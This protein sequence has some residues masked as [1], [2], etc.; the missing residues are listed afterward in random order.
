[1]IWFKNY[2]HHQIYSTNG[3]LLINCKN[4]TSVCFSFLEFCTIFNGKH[5]YFPTLFIFSFWK[6]PYNR[7][8]IWK[9]HSQTK[10]GKYWYLFIFP[11]FRKQNL[12]WKYLAE[13]HIK[14]V[15]KSIFKTYPPSS[16]IIN[17]VYQ[18]VF[19]HIL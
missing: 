17:S 19:T 12:V 8:C 6:P 16:K 1:M 14:Q 7:L 18:V 10:Y 5:I 11:S 3:F 15:L 2:K 9:S 4:F 13:T